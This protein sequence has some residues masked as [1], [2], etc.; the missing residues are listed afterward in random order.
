MALEAGSFIDD[1]VITNPPGTDGKN[2][3]DDHLRLV[4]KV[5]KAT[6]PGMAGAAWRVQNKSSGYTVVAGDNMTLLNC[7]AALT[8][9]LTAAA[10]LGN[11]HMFLAHANGGD[12]TVDPNGTE[13]INGASTS[14]TVADGQTAMILCDATEFYA[15]FMPQAMS[16]TALTLIDDASIGAMRTT[17]GL[18]I[19]TDVA[20]F[21]FVQTFTKAQRG[22]IITLTDGATIT[23]DMD[24]GNN[25]TVTLGGNRTLANPTN[26]TAGQSGSII[27]KQDGTG[28]RTLAYGTQWKFPS[29]TAP[30]LTT[31]ASA[32]DRLDYF[33]ESSSLIHAN[34]ALDVK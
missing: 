4:K 25:F 28:S 29:G 26:L 33:V 12:I 11:Q 13:N 34:L 3:G 20:G 24:D 30:T 32:T 10:T 2:E 8:L 31:T 27:V 18:V 16:A 15:F 19:G 22:A 5:V 14:L 23:P 6:L 21:A 17:L 9:T 7:T 1:L